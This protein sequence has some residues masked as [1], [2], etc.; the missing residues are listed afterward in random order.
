MAA[1]VADDDVVLT[2]KRPVGEEFGEFVFGEEAPVEIVG[3][4]KAFLVFGDS[5][6]LPIG[7]LFAA[8]DNGNHGFIIPFP[9]VIETGELYLSKLHIRF[10]TFATFHKEFLNLFLNEF[11]H[12][13]N[14]S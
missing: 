1:F 14:I 12:D 9:Q 2:G 10:S 4:T 5:G 6:K 8:S 13:Y 11:Y 3:L 7:G